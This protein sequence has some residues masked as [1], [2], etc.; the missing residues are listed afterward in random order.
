[1]KKLLLL[2]VL[3]LSV[4]ISTAQETDRNSLKNIQEDYQLHTRPATDPIVLDGELNEESWKNAAVAS[5]FWMN[6]PQDDVKATRQTEVKVTYDDK[7]LYIGAVCYD[8]SDYVV[9]TLKRDSRFFDSDGFAVVI[10]PVNEKTNGFFF[11]VS[12]MNVQSEDLINSSAFSNMNF[13]WDNKWFSE[14]KRFPDYWVVEIA[15]PFKT[16]R[17]K[18]DIT[19]WGINFIRN[20]LKR[21]EYDTWTRIPINFELYDLGYTGSLMWETS[22]ER[23]K[24]NISLIPYISGSAIQDNLEDKNDAD[25]DAGFDAKV[26]VTSSMNLDLTVNPDFSQVEVDRQQTNLTRFNLFFPERRTFFLENAD[27]FTSFGTPPARPFFSRRIGLD[28]GG[29]PL[30]ILFGARLSGNVNQ[31]LRVGLMNVQTKATDTQAAEN[32]STLAFNQRVLSRSLVKGYAT[33]RQAFIDGEGVN[34]N[35]FGR[36]AGLELNYMNKKGSLNTWVG[37]HISDK[38]GVSKNSDFLN[39]GLGYSG[40]NFSVFTDYI[41]MGT[42]YYADLGFIQR[43]EN[44]DAVKD[45]VFRLGFDHIFNSVNYTIRPKENNFINAHTIGSRLWLDFNPDGSFNERKSHLFY[46]IMFRNTSRFNVNLQDQDVRLLYFT[47]FFRKEGALPLPPDAYRFQR[48]NLEYQSDARKTFAYA[49]T[50]SRGEFYNGTLQQYVLELTYRRQPWGNF[51]LG[52][53]QNELE[54]PEK[55]GETSLKLIS[56]RSEIN[57]SNNLFWTTFFQYNTQRNN[58]NV[59]SRLQWRYKPM[60][61]LYLVYTDNYFTDPFMNSKSRAIVFKL[62]YWLTI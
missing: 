16:L 45:T 2:A 25:F 50:V 17:F 52:Y 5:D 35:D 20:D 32:T 39:L 54:L 37:Y 15:I 43:I 41:R 10:D 53:E 7:F 56:Q 22:P 27:L 47:E 59:N 44:Y 58:F 51:T 18:S 24:T 8:T 42:N 28:A 60:S 38:P 61:D 14:V 13:S 21:N 40:R 6:Y 46:N 4:Q 23:V 1:M 62:N 33:N 29:L 12:P 48:Y 9:Q 19:K 3:V 49:A 26:A 30:P 55:Y 31:N 34:K 36:N 57:F 11:G